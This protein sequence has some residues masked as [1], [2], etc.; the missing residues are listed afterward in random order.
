MRALVYACGIV[1]VLMASSVAT[2]TAADRST[3][4]AKVSPEG[5]PRPVRP[6]LSIG[7]SASTMSAEAET[8]H[9]TPGTFSADAFQHDLFTGAATAEIPIV[10]PAGAAGIAPKIALRYSSSA[11]DELGE[12]DQAQ[13]AGLGWLLDV[14][15]FILRDLKNSTT[16]N[17]DTFKLVFGGGVHDLVL[18]DDAQRVY[19]TKDEAFLKIQYFGE[20]DDYWVLT[21]KDGIQ[22]RFGY[23]ADGK[24]VTRGTEDRKSVV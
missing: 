7:D 6:K 10:V 14:G 17:D 5:P 12:R 24:A 2:I 16:T 22:H 13:S 18:V 11:V 15:G 4:V 1:L 3:H 20:P 21:T 9:A 23:T 19:H 8:A